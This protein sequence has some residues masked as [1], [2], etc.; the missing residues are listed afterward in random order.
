MLP[1]SPR[2]E[3]I[4]GSLTRRVTIVTCN[5]V[6]YCL[7]THAVVLACLPSHYWLD[8]KTRRWGP[9]CLNPYITV[10]LPLTD[11]CPLELVSDAI[12][13]TPISIF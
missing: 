7:Q 4:S 13:I 12:S 3:R 1:G 11:T 2:Q 6:S 8:V 9:R 5:T 10:S